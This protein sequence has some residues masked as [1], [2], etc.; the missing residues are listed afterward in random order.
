M[1]N[2][3]LLF[4]ILLNVCFTPSILNLTSTLNIVQVL[5]WHG[6]RCIFQSQKIIVR[7]FK[8]IDKKFECEVSNESHVKFL[9]AKQLRWILLLLRR[10]QLQCF[11]SLFYKQWH[12]HS[13]AISVFTNH[14]CWVGVIIL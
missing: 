14:F 2:E 5:K 12:S 1:Q 4:S 7:I 11:L 13:Q 3:F 8:S 10:N 9:Y 6:K